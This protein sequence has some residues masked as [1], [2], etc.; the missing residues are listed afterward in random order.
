M[1]PGSHDTEVTQAPGSHDTAVTQAPRFCA[2]FKIR[3][4]PL[5]MPAQGSCDSKVMQP[6]R[7]RDS[8]AMQA[9][10]S[11]FTVFFLNNFKALLLQQ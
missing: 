9:L 1:A 10:G 8:P 3:Q 2:S 5:V 6:Q 4:M 11:K 7:S